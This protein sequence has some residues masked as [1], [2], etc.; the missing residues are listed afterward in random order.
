VKGPLRAGAIQI[1]DMG[2]LT[3]L[4]IRTALRAQ[5]TDESLRQASHARRL[6]LPSA[7][8]LLEA[9]ACSHG[10]RRTACS[11][12]RAAP[13]RQ[14]RGRTRQMSV[15]PTCTDDSGETRRAQRYAAHQERGCRAT[16]GW[17]V[18]L[19]ARPCPAPRHQRLPRA[20]CL[21]QRR[22]SRRILLNAFARARRSDAR[23]QSTAG[24]QKQSRR[25]AAVSAARD[26]SERARGSGVPRR[27][28]DFAGKHVLTMYKKTAQ[29]GETHVTRDTADHPSTALRQCP[30]RPPPNPR[31]PRRGGRRTVQSGR[32]PF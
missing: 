25:P 28:D 15:T 19:N 4:L 12:A 6:D 32:P 27:D 26:A 29:L 30:Y 23:D 11:S 24:R 13:A 7:G 10:A 5:T 14:C 21:H 20:Q 8:G 3:T 22:R 16:G 18:V 31:C 2:S 1:S 17:S 9:G